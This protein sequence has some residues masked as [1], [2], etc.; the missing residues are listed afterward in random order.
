MTPRL[1]SAGLVAL[2]AVAPLTT[3]PAR[4]ERCGGEQ[5]WHLGPG[6][7]GTPPEARLLETWLAR[8]PA[9]ELDRELLTPDEIAALNERNADM[10][11]AWHDQLMARQP[12]P[13][14]VAAELRERLDEIALRVARGE[15]VEDQPGAFQ[16]VGRVIASA[17]P[18]DEIRVVHSV[19]DFRC[20]P[21]AS[22]LYR[23]FI[24]RLFDRNQCSRLHP[25]EIV[26]VLRKTPDDRW[27]YGRAG[28]GVGWVDPAA[29]GPPMTA[30]AMRALRDQTP[31]LTIL[32]D[33]IPARRADGELHLLRF[34][35]GFPIVAAD[36][37]QWQI[38]VPTATGWDDA[39]VD[40]GP[41]VRQGY[42]PLTRR[43]FLALLFARLDDPYGWGG[44]GS[45]RDCS[46][47]LLD[48]A[49]SFDLRLGRN[50]AIQGKSG[51]TVVEVGELGPRDKLAA[52]READS[53]G[54]V[55]LYMPGHIMVYLGDLAGRPFAISAISEYLMPC[56]DGG[57][58]TVRLDRT[59]VT[60][61][62]RGG[63][64]ERRSFLERITQL[65]IF[66][67]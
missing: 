15:Y 46:G 57:H 7:D 13:D 28:H 44:T 45:G 10:I 52:L 30:D 37:Q 51:W 38:L 25:G 66:G 24:D 60:D 2:L 39:F 67:R 40:R 32:D 62:E 6:A 54:I 3:A 63:A 26:R 36:E 50:S 53:R 20:V 43:S 29:L 65:S 17:H 58:R 11:G 22:G 4:A 47:L 35:T 1:A 34:G 61:L 55:F 64:T 21:L 48:A 19:T 5:G 12:D 8:W 56:P 9:E 18:T 33:W 14:A 16:T 27:L 31:R 42:L 49:A 23:K 41:G 59:E